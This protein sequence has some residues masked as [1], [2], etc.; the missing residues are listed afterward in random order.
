MARHI[1]R[2]KAL[3]LAA[4][5]M[6][7]MAV[8]AQGYEVSGESSLTGTFTLTI[9]D[10]DSTSHSYSEKSNKGRFYFAG[11]VEKPTLAMIEHAAMSEPLY[12]YIENA[13]IAIKVNATH[14]EA[15]GIKGSRS[16]SEYRYVLERMHS[17]EEADNFL[18]QY[19]RENNASQFTPFILYRNLGSLDA[20][21]VRQLVRQLTGEACH[22]YHYTMLRR[23]M[24]QSPAVSEGGEMPDF[25]YL[26]SRKNRCTFAQTRNEEGYT[27]VFFTAPWCD[28]C[29]RQ[30]EQAAR[31][32]E[33]Q[34]AKL[35]V[36]DIDDNPNGW[37]AQNLKQLSVDHLPYMILVDK[38]GIV[39]SSDMRTWELE[40]KFPAK[41]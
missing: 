26:D 9:F 39:V 38:D 34:Q 3:L 5:L 25:A 28:I 18:R 6:L 22:T 27:L 24:R 37:D 10:G 32:L 11:Q 19:V 40:R 33:P 15:S 13:P 7:P 17:A 30:R 4:V 14:P 36:I 20:V 2:I 41:R 21:V 12:F 29:Q 23:W 1:V 16:N 35:L 8:G 31:L